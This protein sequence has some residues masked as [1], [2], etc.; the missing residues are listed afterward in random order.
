VEWEPK[1]SEGD[2]QQIV[3][4]YNWELFQSKNNIRFQVGRMNN[5]NGPAY[6]ITYP[7]TSDFFNNKHSIILTYNPSDNSYI[8]MYI[9]GNFVERVYFK[10]DT[11]W[12][13]Y[14]EQNISLGRSNHGGTEN[15]IG[16]IYTVRII[17]KDILTKYYQINF[18]I[19]TS[20]VKIP[21]IT[22]AT[23][24]IN[25]MILHAVKK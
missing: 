6:Y 17:S 23:S 24:T 19:N 15:F 5:E 8:E 12:K 22:V 9:D 20:L 2:T 14:G 7:I 25:T 11:I 16:Q 3:G 18:K 21:I 4:H 13:K 1:D 10:T